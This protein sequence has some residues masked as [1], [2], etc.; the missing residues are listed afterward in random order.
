MSKLSP[1]MQQYM[2]TK[3]QY[4]DSILFYRLGDFY[5][6]F[7]EDAITVSR[8]LDLVLTGKNCGLPERAPMC[9]VPHHSVEQYIKKLIE[10]GYKVAIGEQ[11]SDPAQSKGLVERDVIRVVTPGTVFE[12]NLIEDDKN[13][14]ILAVYLDG[15]RCGLA[16]CDVSTGEFYLKELGDKPSGENVVEAIRKIA[17]AEMV[18][19]DATFA[20][21]RDLLTEQERL[22][23]STFMNFALDREGALVAIKEQF[24][25]ATLDG[26][27]LSDDGGA[28][29]ASAALLGYLNATQKVKLVHINY[30]QAA[31]EGDYVEL[32]VSTQRNLELTRTMMGN[33]K[34][35]S[36]LW[37]LDKTKTAHGVRLL[38]SWIEQPLMQKK[39]IERRLEAVGELKDSFTLME[40]L[41]GALGAT[42]DISRLISKISY[43][44]L[45]A[46]DA[47]AIGQTLAQLPQIKQ[48]LS[49]CSSF[50]LKGAAKK[51]DTLPD[52]QRHIM[53]ALVDEPPISIKEGNL[54][55]PG[56]DKEVDEYKSALTDGQSWLAAMEEREKESTGIKNLKIGYNKVF[57]YY[58]EVTKSQYDLVPYRYVRKQTLVNAERFITEELKQLEDK[59][60]GAE[61]ACIKKEYQL[62]CQLRERIAEELESLQQIANIL[63]NMDALQSLA[64]CAYENNYVQPTLNSSGSITIQEGRHPVVEKMVKGFVPNDTLLDNKEN[65]FLVITGPNMSGKSTYMR[66]VA[67]MTIMAHIGS[68]VPAK[69]A[70]ICMVDRIFTR[71]GASD[72]LASGRSTFMVEMVETANILNNATQKSLIILD[73][74]GRGTSTFDGLSIAWAASEYL[75]NQTKAKALFATHYHELSE[76]EGRMPGVKNYCILAREAQDEIIF[77]HRIVR[78]GTDKS[79]GIQVAKMAGVPDAVVDR[80]KEILAELRHLDVDGHIL[81]DHPEQE[82]ISLLA[83]DEQVAQIMRQ[84]Q[85]I[86]VSS[87]TPLDALNVLNQ[88][89]NKAGKL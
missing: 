80:A 7:F 47:L 21:L 84:L 67:L 15:S 60:L 62:F 19:N 1:M 24:G 17:P 4:P 82:Q 86:D 53:D 40:D 73:E 51:L 13:N 58:I 78:G 18:M 28:L 34:R 55:R 23:V 46:R 2:L 54:I 72:D 68:F 45:N 49:S 56:Y 52:L 69:S 35:G 59:I 32:D 87:M 77:L 48:L 5:E 3:E 70:D 83:G 89:S 88:L 63:A 11:L 44:S 14:Y 37:V 66:Q 64:F 29:I 39:A 61:D 9:G 71:V 74:I 20:L 8:E 16:Y 42:Y 10:K 65:R 79:F 12:Q 50:L 31:N 33:A 41:R 57:G 85:Q 6:M 81:G 43:G 75:C 27:G 25:I 22:Q 38:R 36:L 76:L 30:V 26:L